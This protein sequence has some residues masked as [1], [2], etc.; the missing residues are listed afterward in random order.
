MRRGIL[1]VVSGPSGVGKTSMI[2][3]IISE[4]EDA[5]FSVSCTTRPKR[6]GE[7]DGEDYFFVSEEEFKRMIEEDAFLEWARVHGY[8]Y[9]TPRK[10]VE[11]TVNKGKD[12]ILDIDVQGALSVK[13]KVED[14]VY[15]FIAPPSI[16]DLRERLEKRKTEDKE[17]MERRLEDARWEL[18]LIEEF[19]YLIINRDLVEAINDLKS[20]MRSERLKT[21][22]QKEM[23]EKYRME[24]MG[25][26]GK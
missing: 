20:I 14:A 25:W 13:K 17:A 16:E 8:L 18:Q 4:M 10:F 19:D 21:A 1:F 23:I 12:V 15:I 24:V 22:R 26:K 5:V 7:V 3:S 6:P 11:D 9:G 2:K